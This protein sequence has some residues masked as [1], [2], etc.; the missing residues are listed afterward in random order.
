MH[1]IAAKL[2]PNCGATQAQINLLFRV[3]GSEQ[4]VQDEEIMAG[5]GGAAS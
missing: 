2:Q 5:I 4:A 3:K 1:T